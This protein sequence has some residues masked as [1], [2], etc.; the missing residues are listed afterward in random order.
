MDMDYM[1]LT[2]VGVYH[3]DRR[4]RCLDFLIETI[5]ELMGKIYGSE[6]LLRDDE[7]K[8]N[9]NIYKDILTTFKESIDRNQFLDQEWEKK[10]SI[11]DA[12]SRGCWITSNDLLKKLW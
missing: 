7:M 6:T 3:F 5:P 12:G 10:V 8:D 4:S 2:R 1:K 9:E 11:Q